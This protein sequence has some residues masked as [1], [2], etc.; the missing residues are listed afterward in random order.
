M[1][2]KKII[3]ILRFSTASLQFEKTKISNQILSNYLI[4]KKNYL[5]IIK[6]AN[7]IATRNL[8]YFIF[9]R[10]SVGIIGSILFS[11]TVLF[12]FFPI[13]FPIILSFYIRGIIFFKNYI[14][15]NF[16]SIIK[17]IRY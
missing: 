10:F 7:K 15:K 8:G 3:E 17:K 16:L 11:F 5:G 4:T 9:F 1:N 14:L 12:L 13:F 2:N 6:N